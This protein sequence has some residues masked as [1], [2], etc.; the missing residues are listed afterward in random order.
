M[1]TYMTFKEIKE[2]IRGNTLEAKGLSF[3]IDTKGNVWHNGKKN[4]NLLNDDVLV[5]VD[6]RD[7]KLEAEGGH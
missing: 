2:N 6:L 7:V 4:N 1:T 5:A 3:V